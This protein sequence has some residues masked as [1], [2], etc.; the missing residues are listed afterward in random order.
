M[1]KLTNSC[2]FPE[3]CS[4]KQFVKAA[5]TKF[6]FPKAAGNSMRKFFLTKNLMYSK[7]KVEYM[8]MGPNRCNGPS[9]CMYRLYPLTPQVK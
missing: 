8:P 5:S 1:K 2:G 3:S 7:R 4:H 9:R 6:G